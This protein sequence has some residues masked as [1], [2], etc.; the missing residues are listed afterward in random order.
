MANTAIA[1]AA[2]TLDVADTAQDVVA[3][4]LANRKYLYIKNMDNSEIYIGPSGVSAADGFPLSPKSIAELRIGA[5][6]DIEF[7]GASG[8]TPDIRTM[9]LS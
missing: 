7:V 8:K 1:S 4:P 2:E 3:S 6:V 5:A 9:E